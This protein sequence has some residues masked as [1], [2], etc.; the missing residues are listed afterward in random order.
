MELSDRFEA[1]I[2][3][4][5]GRQAE[6]ACMAA[7]SDDVADFAAFFPPPFGAGANAAAVTPPRCAAG[8]GCSP[9]PLP[10]QLCCT[11]EGTYPD[12]PL[13]GIIMLT[14]RGTVPIGIGATDGTRGMIVE[15][16]MGTGGMTG[17]YGAGGAMLCEG[18]T[19][20]TT[21]GGTEGSVGGG[22]VGNT[23]PFIGIIIGGPNPGA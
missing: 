13:L 16:G 22:I 18:G 21:I 9:A 8:R 11:L 2:A 12:V 14:G 4:A 15:A 19:V 3:R 17:M 20:G 1:L 5:V 10:I 6:L 23:L 7:A